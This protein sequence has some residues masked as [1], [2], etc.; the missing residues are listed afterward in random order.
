MEPILWGFEE[1]EKLNIFIPV[2]TAIIRKGHIRRSYHN[3]SIIFRYTL[4]IRPA[5]V[6]DG[7]GAA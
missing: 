3:R 7:G 5:H 2:G 4:F 6:E 1:R